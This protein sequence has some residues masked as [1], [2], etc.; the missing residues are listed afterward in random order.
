VYGPVEQDSRP[1]TLSKKEL[2]ISTADTANTLYRKIKK[3]ELEMFQETWPELVSSRVSRV[4]QNDDAGSF[5]KRGDLFQEQIQKI[6]LGETTTPRKFITKLTALTDRSNRR[7][8]V[9]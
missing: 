7:G 6:K 2:Q 9:F 3:L 5:H 8:C 1:A 4:P